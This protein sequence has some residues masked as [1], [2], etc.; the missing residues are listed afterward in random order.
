MPCRESL[1][2]TLFSSFLVFNH[3]M[4]LHHPCIPGPLAIKLFVQSVWYQTPPITTC[5][6]AEIELM[7]PQPLSGFLGLQ[8][9]SLGFWGGSLLIEKPKPSQPQTVQERTCTNKHESGARALGLRD[10]T[11]TERAPARV[12]PTYNKP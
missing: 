9:G 4:R 7:H 3:E 1:E 6:F 2:I 8:F 10:N 11:E 12:P 5:R